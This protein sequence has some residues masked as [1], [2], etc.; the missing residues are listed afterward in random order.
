MW[1]GGGRIPCRPTGGR[2]CDLGCVGQ[3]LWVSVPSSV[4]HPQLQRVARFRVVVR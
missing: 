3:P 1:E 2:L 4:A